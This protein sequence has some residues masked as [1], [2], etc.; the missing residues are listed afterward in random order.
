MLH[1]RPSL[2][3]VQSEHHHSAEKRLVLEGVGG[4]VVCVRVPETARGEEGS[5]R[6]EGRRG[7][8]KR[9]GEVDERRGAQR[10]ESWRGEE[11]SGG[12]REERSKR[13]KG[14]QIGKRRRLRQG[15]ANQTHRKVIIEG[16][17]CNIRGTCL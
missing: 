5:L 1:A 12:S 14:G 3:E 10:E 7:G 17:A 16:R 13:A 15:K 2:D 6:E 11:R 8:E 9:R 4:V